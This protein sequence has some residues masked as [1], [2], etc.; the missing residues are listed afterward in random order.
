M[1]KHSCT[2]DALLPRVVAADDWL[3]LDIKTPFVPTANVVSD[4]LRREGHADRL[5][6]QL[7]RPEDV[8]WFETAVKEFELPRPIITA[9]AAKRSVN[10]LASQVSRLRA[11]AFTV[12]INKLPALRV[13]PGLPLLVH[14]IHDCKDWR[15]ASIYPVRGIYTI[16][17]LNLSNCTSH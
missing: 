12:A 9:Y 2:L 13:D 8:R 6:F 4:V 15:E 3:V 16:S 14:P 17:Q 7:Y 1:P 11:A 5:I 10:H